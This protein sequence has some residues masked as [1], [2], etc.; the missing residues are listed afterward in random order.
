MERTKAHINEKRDQTICSLF[1]STYF[2]SLGL[3]LFTYQP[4]QVNEQL[5][6]RYPSTT[7]PVNIE[8][9]STGF[10]AR[11]VVALFPE[12]HID[13]TQHEDDLIFYF[14]N[15]FV[16]RHRKITKKILDDVTSE[17][18][19]PLIRY[20]SE[21]QIEEAACHWVWLHEYHH[22]QEPLP[23]PKNIWLKS[24]KPLA[25]LEELRAD[26]SGMLTCMED[27]TLPQELAELTWQFIF[28]ERLLRYSVEGIPTPNY[29]AIGSQVLFNFLIENEGIYI[30]RGYIRILKS[31]PEVIK[32]FISK[33]NEIESM[34]FRVEPPEVQ[35]LL[36][37]FVNRYA[38]FDLDTNR[39]SHGKFF[40]DIKSRLNV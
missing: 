31:L 23:L 17:N 11:L 18:D 28:A 25:G 7:M 22:R 38:S 34:I 2:P 35:R 26:L 32:L 10:E 27:S 36:L 19:F 4:L 12:N 5:A 24:L 15:K 30:E 16:A 6:R 21:Q 29:D 39:Y 40:S 1:S 13:G 33:I 20:A 3:D 9:M 14:I 8:R 37:S